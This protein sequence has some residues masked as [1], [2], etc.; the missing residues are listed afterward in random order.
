MTSTF[1]TPPAAPITRG[2]LYLFQIKAN[3]PTTDLMLNSLALESKKR[4]GNIA[5]ELH[6]L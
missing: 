6:I 5:Q 4:R 1:S 2:A 3:N